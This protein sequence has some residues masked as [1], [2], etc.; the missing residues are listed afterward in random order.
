MVSCSLNNNNNGLYCL[1]YAMAV[2]GTVSSSR[3]TTELPMQSLSC[4]QSSTLTWLLRDCTSAEAI[5]TD[6][7][8]RPPGKGHWCKPSSIRALVILGERLMSVQRKN[9]QPRQCHSYSTP[10]FIPTVGH[11]SY[12]THP[13]FFKPVPAKSERKLLCLPPQPWRNYTRA[14]QLCS[15]NWSEATEWLSPAIL[16]GQPACKEPGLGAGE[17]RRGAPWR[18]FNSVAFVKWQ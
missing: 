10:M 17:A 1:L 2:R 4:F 7:R 11:H 9:K 8:R 13:C 18:Q 3:R 14:T 12:E 15:W 16:A 5:I 6:I